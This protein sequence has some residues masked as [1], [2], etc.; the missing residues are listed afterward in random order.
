MRSAQTKNPGVAGG[1]QTAERYPGIGALLAAPGR[2]RSVSCFKAKQAVFQQGDPSDA[3]FYIL[4]GRIRLIVLSEYGKK[5]AVGLLAAGEFFGESCLVNGAV[6]RASAIAMSRSKIVRI[7]RDAMTSLL[8]E[9]PAVSDGFM[10]F[11][12]SRNVQM[13]SDLADQLFNSSE[14]RL[15]RVLLLLAD[16]GK[17]GTM[18]VAIPKISQDVLASKVGASRTRINYFMNKFRKLGF[19]EYG[20]AE[21]GGLKVHPSLLNIIVPD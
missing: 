8:Q 15:A 14:Q 6:H 12:L 20:T 21:D 10:A 17:G 13:E 16:F 1:R 7:E 18:A 3:V 5:G 11:L 19:I 9:Q 4:D 2:G